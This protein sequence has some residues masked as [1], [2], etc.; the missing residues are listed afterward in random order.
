MARLTA[1]EQEAQQLVG[2]AHEQAA[3]HLTESTHRTEGDIAE[4]RRQAASERERDELN[5]ETEAQRK[6]AEIRAKAAPN[7]DK[8]RQAVIA[9]ILPAGTQGAASL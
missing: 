8:I 7:R 1:A 5:I 2:Q 3:A 9:R 4:M 6:V